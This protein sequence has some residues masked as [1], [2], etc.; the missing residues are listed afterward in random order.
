MLPTR[1]SAASSICLVVPTEVGSGFQ[2][3]VNRYLASHPAGVGNSD[4]VDAEGTVGQQCKLEAYH[5]NLRDLLVP[6]KS[7]PFNK[8]FLQT[9]LAPDDEYFLQ[10]GRHPTFILLLMD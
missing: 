3:F 1:R 6:S 8:K 10:Q 5:A 2:Q 9:I 4:G 7:K